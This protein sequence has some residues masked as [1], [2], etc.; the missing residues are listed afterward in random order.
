ML[1]EEEDGESRAVGAAAFSVQA[2]EGDT[3]QRY[4]ELC[5][6]LNMD[7]RARCEAWL[8]YQNMKRNFT[9]EGNDLH[10]L[11]RALYMACRKAVPTVSKGTAEGNYVSL[12]R[13]LCC[14]EQSL[15]EFFNKMKK[16]EDMANLPA[17]FR[18]RTERIERNF[19]ISAV[20]FK[21]YKPIFQ[22]IFRYPQDQP[23][24]QRGRK[25]RRQPCTVTEVLQF[26]WVLFVH[27]KGNFPMISDDLVNYCHL[28][29]CALDLVYGNAL[30]CPNCK[31]LLNPNFKVFLIVGLTEDFH[32]KDYKVSSDPPC[33]I[34]KLCSLY[35]GLALEAKGIK[36]HFWK[37]YIRKIFDKKLLKGKDENLTG[38]LDPGS[39]GDSFAGEMVFCVGLLPAVDPTELIWSLL[40]SS[41]FIKV[42]SSL[43]RLRFCTCSEV[44]FQSTGGAH[45]PRCAC[46]HYPTQLATHD[47]PASGKISCLRFA[48]YSANS[49]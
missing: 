6:S 39:F 16:W 2:E 17:Q 46:P 48:I 47:S 23:R 33:I 42:H 22:G 1:G 11:A 21:K 44:K 13:I 29:L 25:Q 15:I 26:C 24:Q 28:L 41:C 19:T 40:S 5:S 36:E 38:F 18:E 3:R 32:N 31:E 8:S 7:G 37:P 9:L 12:T 10:W 14:S 34:E 49:K 4:E 27:A 30:Q 45:W 43:G 35:Y 20:I